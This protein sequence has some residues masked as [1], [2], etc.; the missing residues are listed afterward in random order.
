VRIADATHEL[1]GD[2][3]R[4]V[5]GEGGFGIAT[6]AFSVDP[7]DEPVAYGWYGLEQDPSTFVPTK[8]EFAQVF[9]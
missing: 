6:I 3:S 4:P 5:G 8:I 7:S 1:H 2:D 9:Q